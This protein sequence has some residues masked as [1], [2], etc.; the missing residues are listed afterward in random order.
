[1]IRETFTEAGFPVPM[2]GYS[3]Q[4]MHSAPPLDVARSA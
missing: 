4:Q 2:P 3:V 1:M